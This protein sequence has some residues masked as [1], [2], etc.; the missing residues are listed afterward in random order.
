M[1]I[2]VVGSKG[3]VGSSLMVLGSTYKFEMFGF[4]LPEIDITSSQSIKERYDEVNPDLVIN[5]AAFTAVDNAEEEV[6]LSYQINDLGTEY[7]ADACEM[8]GI[9]LFHISTDYVFD[10]DEG[11]YL[12]SS[13]VNP[14]SV[15][16]ASKLAGEIS[17]KNHC[18]KTMI[19]RTSWVFSEYGSNFLKTMISLARTK[20]ELGVVQDQKGSPTSARHIAEALLQLALQY[21]TEQNVFKTY[22]FTGAPY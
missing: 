17:A 2:L 18:S 10:G 9:P 11:M 7:L 20:D 21:K 22:H 3:Q 5:A 12:E 8:R 14:Q 16:G 4:D 6:E 15:Y 1:K 19:L 13:Q